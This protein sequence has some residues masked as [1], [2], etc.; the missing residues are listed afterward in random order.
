MTKQKTTPDLPFVMPGDNV[1]EFILAT[2]P[3]TASTIAAT[4]TT[5]DTTVKVGTGLRIVKTSSSTAVY[6]TLAG[7]LMQQHNNHNS[8][9]VQVRNHQGRYRPLLHDRVVGVIQDRIG[10]DG[11]GGDMYAVAIGSS[12]PAT[13]SNLAFEGATKRNKPILRPGMVVYARIA[14]VPKHL[15]TVLSCQLGPHDVGQLGLTRRDWMT[16]E[17]A[18]GILQGGTVLRVSSHW[19]QQ[20]LHDPQHVI[21][22]ELTK[23]ALPAEVAV[24]TNG[25]IWIHAGHD[26]S[27]TVVMYNI[28]RNTAS[29]NLTEPQTRAMIRQMIAH[30][31]QQQQQ[32][33]D[34]LHEQDN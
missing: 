10:S 25:W 30:Y 27:A 3:D 8:F 26:P 32:R 24:G 5:I 20:V 4:A 23:A 21:W 1:T 13:L 33:Q 7:Q 34:L 9:Y 28:W 31:K 18:Y 11:D 29:G 14:T 17:G 12:H 16:E 15:D 22:Q 2:T 6:A 19:T